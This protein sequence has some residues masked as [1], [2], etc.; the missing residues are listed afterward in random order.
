MICKSKSSVAVWNCQQIV[1]FLPLIIILNF[2]RCLLLCF[3]DCQIKLQTARFVFFAR[4]LPKCTSTTVT[5]IFP[6]FHTLQLEKMHWKTFQN[7]TEKEQNSEFIFEI[8]CWRELVISTFWIEIQNVIYP[9]KLQK[10]NVGNYA[11]VKAKMYCKD[12]MK[13]EV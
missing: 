3:I 9:K 6:P 7:R 2:I 8:L 4:W 5:A 11:S 13:A 12:K 1:I 10:Y